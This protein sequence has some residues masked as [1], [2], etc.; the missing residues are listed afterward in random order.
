M[1][2]QKITVD[3]LMPTMTTTIAGVAEEFV[4]DGKTFLV[5]NGTVNSTTVTIVTG[6]TV[7]GLALQ[8]REVAIALDEQ[9]LIGPFNRAY[10]NDAEGKVSVSADQVI[11]IAAVSF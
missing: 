1:N 9:I 11:E 8:D 4:N 10:Y 7:E 3:G 5:I 6:Y 2:V